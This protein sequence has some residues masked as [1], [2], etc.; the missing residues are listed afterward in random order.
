MRAHVPESAKEELSYTYKKVCQN[1][2]NYSA[3]H[4]RSTL[5]PGVHDTESC[6]D[7]AKSLHGGTMSRAIADAAD[8]SLHR[9]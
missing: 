1:F 9:I 5:M 4:L 7:R 2:S 6:E 3:F 8:V